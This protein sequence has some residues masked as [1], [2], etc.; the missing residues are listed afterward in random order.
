[1]ISYDQFLLM[2]NQT[3]VRVWL[4][5]ANGYNEDIDSDYETLIG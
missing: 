1:M 5:Y 2:K 3:T 4:D